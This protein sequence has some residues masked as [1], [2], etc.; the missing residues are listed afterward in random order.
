MKWI[1]WGI[2]YT[3]ELTGI[4]PYNKALCDHLRR[5]GHEVRML[6]TF[7]YY[8]EW[9]KRPGDGWRLYGREEIEGVDVLRCWHYVPGRVT[10]LKR[11][12]HELSFVA[13][14]ALRL[15]LAMS[16]ADGVVVVSPPLLLGWAA[17]WVGWLRGIPYCVHVQDLQ[18]DAAVSL[19]MLKPGLFVRAL[20][21][22]ER[23]A[24]RHARFVSGIS[25]V[26]VGAFRHK[27]VEEDRAVLFPNG[28][29][30]PDLE[31]LPERGLFRKR[32]GIGEDE[33]L[34][35][36][37]G[38]LGIKQ[39]LEVLLEAAETLSES[40][41]RMVI[42]GEGAFRKAIEQH[43]SQHPDS[44][45]VKLLPIQPGAHYEQMLCDADVCLVTQRPGTGAYFMPSKVLPT[46]AMAKPILAS[47]DA[48]SPLSRAIEEADCGAF[49]PAGNGTALAELLDRYASMS[50]EA[51][52]EKGANGRRTIARFEMEKVLAAFEAE[53]TR[54]F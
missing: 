45:R 42:A 33:F 21:W 1:V 36:Y 5:Q 43:V 20:Y 47:A 46:L 41:V 50:A 35:V 32:E 12:L 3:P 51:L 24:Y 37:S 38:N 13:T 23:V 17:G 29:R 14:S 15:L 48:D 53:L 7:P 4:A 22:L 19:R 26:M 8:P 52:A 18:P 54:R 11:I 30:L 40:R 28:V 49:A 34:A 44:L 39:G 9:K 6:T 16:R 27:G 31:K 25:E 2:N 10:A